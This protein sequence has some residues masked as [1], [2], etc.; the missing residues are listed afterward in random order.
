MLASALGFSYPA[1]AA[2][3]PLFAVLL[4]LIIGIIIFGLFY[5]MYLSLEKHHRI[6]KNRSTSKAWMT[7]FLILL[8]I[9]L[10]YLGVTYYYAYVANSNAPILLFSNALTASNSIGIVLNGST[11]TPGMTSCAN[12]LYNESL[13]AGKKP[14]LVY[15][16]GTSC[17]IKGASTTSGACLNSLVKSGTPFIM[18]T[19]SN[20]SEIRAYSMYGTALYAQGNSNFMSYC[21]PSFFLK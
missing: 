9:I 5:G 7:L 18:L 2:S 12:I 11:T 1:A 4:S 16:S 19:N 14:T 20:V 15:V 6:R 8:V 17:S 21:Y 10:I 13:A 3:M